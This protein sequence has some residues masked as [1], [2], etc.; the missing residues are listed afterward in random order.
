MLPYELLAFSA[1]SLEYLALD[2]CPFDWDALNSGPIRSFK[3]TVLHVFYPTDSDAPH[4]LP[5]SELLAILAPMISL[6]ELRLRNIFEANC[7]DLLMEWEASS[8]TMFPALRILD[9]QANIQICSGF[10][11]SVSASNLVE[12]EVECNTTG[13]TSLF[14][15]RPF[16]SGISKLAPR[17][18]YKILTAIYQTGKLWIA[19]QGNQTRTFSRIVVPVPHNSGPILA[20]IIQKL[21]DMSSV[22]SAERLK[23]DFSK[24][25]HTK[26]MEDTWVYLLQRSNKVSLLDLGSYP[27]AYILRTLYRNAKNVLEA[28]EQG[29]AIGILLPLLETIAVP[30]SPR[31]CML[32]DIIAELREI[33][34]APIDPY[35]MLRE[36]DTN[37]VLRERAVEWLEGNVTNGHLSSVTEDKSDS[38]GSEV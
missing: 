15:I 10:L 24:D 35:V 20:Y 25:V 7:E 16:M 5:V 28:Q 11:N 19:L 36:M 4:A 2:N 22:H 37:R 18:P 13:D 17:E 14:A 31:Q 3:L 30:A 1:P 21:A 9:I 12:L 29:E 34:G 27:V 38:E 33:V 8:A 26:I 23:I 6:Q 32:V